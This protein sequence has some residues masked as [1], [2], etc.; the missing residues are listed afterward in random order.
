MLHTFHSPSL[1]RVVWESLFGLRNSGIVEFIPT[2]DNS[3]TMTVSVSF[4]AP[5][6]IERL[7][8]GIF[9]DFLRNKLLKWS[10]E[11]FRDAVKGDLALERG[12]VELGD[13]LSGAVEGRATV[14]STAIEATLSA[15]AYNQT[16]GDFL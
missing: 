8:E 4:L 10:L 7:F 5:R 6:G 14:L 2:S 12:D 3:C 9:E 11:M 1:H 15:Y 16:N 13:A